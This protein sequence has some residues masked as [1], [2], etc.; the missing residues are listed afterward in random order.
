MAKRQINLVAFAAIYL[1]FLA[2]YDGWGRSPLTPGEVEGYLAN[3][4]ENAEGV[5][6]LNRLRKM[7][8]NDDGEELF[9]L[10]LKLVKMH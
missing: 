4:P 2:W 6:F 7:G 10:N 5:E 9:M 3:V 8:A 1:V